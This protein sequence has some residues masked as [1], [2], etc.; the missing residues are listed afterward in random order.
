MFLACFHSF[1][2]WDGSI[3]DMPLVAWLLVLSDIGL[4]LAYLVISWGIY[5]YARARDVPFR[6]VAV[7]FAVFINLCGLTHIAKAVVLFVPAFWAQA[8]VQC[9][10]LVVS[11]FTAGACVARFD[12][13]A[14][15]LRKRAE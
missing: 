6:W 8:L 14:A 1:P 13:I 3:A 2:G 9:A 11:A 4:F 10:T 15:T 12:A 5:G 7:L